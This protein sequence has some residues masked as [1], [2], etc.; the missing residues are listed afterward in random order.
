LQPDTAELGV[1]AHVAR[2]GELHGR[3]ETQEFLDGQT[4][5]IPVLLQPVAQPRVLQELMNRPA[6][7]MCGRLVPRKE[8]E[9][10]HSHHLIAADPTAFLL[11]PHKLRDETLAAMV[12]YGFE[13]IL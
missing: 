5:A 4:G 3:D 10:E 7:Q 1:L 9:K 13:L 12:A 11:H 2:L 8:E 6:D